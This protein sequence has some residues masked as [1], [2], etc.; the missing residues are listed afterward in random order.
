MARVP[1]TTYLKLC[2]EF[3]D[4]EQHKNHDAA[5][6]FYMNYAAQAQGSILEP[7]CGTGRFLIPI[8]QAGYD[9][10]GFDASAH[11]L[12][13]CKQKCAALGIMQPPVWQTFVQDFSAEKTYELIFVPYGSWGLITSIDDSQ[14]A[15]GVMFKHLANDGTLILEVETVASLP[16]P[17]GVWRRGVSRRADGSAI[18]IN[19]LT[20]YNQETQIF[21][22]LCRYESIV[23]GK[24]VATETEN[25]EQYLYHFDQ[26]DQMLK[27]AG[28]TQIKKYSDYNKNP[29]IDP[30]IHTIIY[31][32]RK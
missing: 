25:Y 13:A 3:Y 17:C 7:M 29:A 18:A 27:T 5:L 19:T 15:L 2:T 24:I 21:R 4:L 30:Q 1:L 32:C 6:A 12:D 23:D 8:L 11:M 9:I 28:F 14:H 16:E 20:S 26:M 22:S 31:E 10:Q